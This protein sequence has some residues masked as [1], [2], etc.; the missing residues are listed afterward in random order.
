MTATGFAWFAGNF[1]TADSNWVAWLSAHALF[2]YRGPLVA[3]VL[4][5][6]RDQ[7][8]RLLD[9]TVIGGGYA[10]AVVTPIWQSEAASVALAGCLAAVASASYLRADGKSGVNASPP[11]R[12]R[13]SS[14]S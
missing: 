4:S 3:L 13:R 14:A 11:G 8:S 12:R 2:W 5:Y 7:R 6:P 9:R 10:A 1:V